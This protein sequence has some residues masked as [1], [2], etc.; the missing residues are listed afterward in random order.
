MSSPMTVL[1][2]IIEFCNIYSMSTILF[3]FCLM[4]VYITIY[5]MHV[6]DPMVRASSSPNGTP[7]YQTIVD[8]VFIPFTFK[9]QEPSKCQLTG[10]SF[11][12]SSLIP[13]S[14]QCYWGVEIAEFFKVLGLNWRSRQLLLDID[15][16]LEGKY[17]SKTESGS[18][19]PCGETSFSSEPSHTLSPTSLG[20]SPRSRYPLVVFL[21]RDVMEGEGIA[22][23]DVI[24]MVNIIHIQDDVFKTETG[25]LF[26][27]IKQ[28]IGRISCLKQLYVEPTESD[29]GDGVDSDEGPSYSAMRYDVMQGD[30]NNIAGPEDS[31]VVKSGTTEDRGD[32]GSSTNVDRGYSPDG[33]ARSSDTNVDRGDRTDGDARSSDTNVDRSDSPDG[34]AA[35]RGTTEDH[36]E[37]PDGGAARSGT[38][39]VVCR[40]YRVS[41]ALLPCRHTCVCARCFGK[42]SACPMCRSDIRSFFCV[43]EEEDM[44]LSEPPGGDLDGLNMGQ[45]FMYWNNRLNDWLGFT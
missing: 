37:S 16:F 13:W 43:T 41:R 12:V 3:V 36:S 14:L 9:L 27:Y 38:L 31:C 5:R 11:T 34:G 39:C 1:S 15:R 23:Y 21:C 44:S 24:A 18:Q 29:E 45:R 28:E 8:K 25:I 10:A 30:P 40:V 42:L 33:G 7:V 19:L 6:N 32:A 26:Q 4:T 35:G 17:I 20:L 22:P 2:S